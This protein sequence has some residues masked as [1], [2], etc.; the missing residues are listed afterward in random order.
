[1]HDHVRI[2]YI[3]T[4]SMHASAHTE[5]VQSAKW[6]MRMA[7]QWSYDLSLSSGILV[8][9]KKRATMRWS[10]WLP[11]G[12]D[13]STP[14]WKAGLRVNGPA[15]HEE[16]LLGMFT[17]VDLIQVYLIGFPTSS[18]ITLHVPPST[19]G[20]PWHPCYPNPAWVAVG[21]RT[22]RTSLLLPKLVYGDCS[23]M[24]SRFMGA[25][26]VKFHGVSKMPMAR[27]KAYNM[28]NLSGEV[29]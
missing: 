16:S 9:E 7:T 15:T 28:S 21:T 5:R 17:V 10:T 18:W 3:A 2:S 25:W 13:P 24:S 1:M 23:W 19:E 20:Q 11:N 26:R 12:M 29:E 6:S 8:C 14:S 27:F 4:Q 22:L